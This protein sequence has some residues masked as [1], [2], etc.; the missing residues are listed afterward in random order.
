MQEIIT[1][2]ETLV[3]TL[4]ETVTAY[5]LAEDKPAYKEFR[6]LRTIGQDLKKTGQELRIAVLEVQKAKKK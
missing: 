2:L 3:R 1:K 5:E 4:K 6:A